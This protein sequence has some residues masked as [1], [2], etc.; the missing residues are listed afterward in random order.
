MAQNLGARH[1]NWKSAARLEP[2]GNIAPAEAK[3]RYYSMLDGAAMA[4]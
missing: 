1:W 2:I 4:E 3:E